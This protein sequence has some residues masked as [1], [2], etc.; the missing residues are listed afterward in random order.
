METENARYE[1]LVRRYRELNSMVAV[2]QGEMAEIK[3]QI[4]EEVPVGWKLTVDGVPCHKRLPNRIFDI[5]AAMSVLTP[6][7]KAQ[8]VVTRYDEK[9]VRQ[10]VEAAGLLEDCMVRKPD[11][12]NVTKIS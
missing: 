4:E 1:A 3:H 6:E 10:H 5:V 7:Q 11:A 8:C 9:L 2:I 12:P